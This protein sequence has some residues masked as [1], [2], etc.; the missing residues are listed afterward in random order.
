MDIQMKIVFACYKFS[1]ATISGLI[2]W[3]THSLYS[4]VAIC[5]SGDDGIGAV[6]E[7]IDTGFVKAKTLGENH[8]AGTFVDLFEYGDKYPVDTAAVIAELE[9][10]VGMRYDFAGIASFLTGNRIPPNPCAV[11]CSN[12][13]QRASIAGGVPLQNLA[14]HNMMPSHVAMSLALEFKQTVQI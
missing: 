3:W 11:Q 13:A 10:M 2:G 9:S 7:A 8:D 12:A 4:H 1:P 5:V 6:Y 14:A